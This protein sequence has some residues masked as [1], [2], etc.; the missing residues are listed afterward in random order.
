MLTQTMSSTGMSMAIESVSPEIASWW[1]QMNTHNRNLNK[2]RVSQLAD[3]MR[4][5][6]WVVNG[7]P[8]QFDREG[9]LINGQHRLH[10]IVMSGVT[11]DM[12]V[13]RGLDPR[14]Q[15]TIDIGSSR[16]MVAILTLNGISSGIGKSAIAVADYRLTHHADVLWKQ[17]NMP[18]RMQQLQMIKERHDEY[19]DGVNFGWAAGRAFGAHRTA[20]GLLSILAQ[21]SAS[22][23]WMEFHTGIT[24]GVGLGMDDPRLRLRNLFIRRNSNPSGNWMQQM[25]VALCIKAYNAYIEGRGI[26]N[27]RFT[28]D[29]LPMPTVTA[30]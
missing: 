12:L 20:Y 5:G 7:E 25:T 16:S 30:I 2:S 3:D 29:E 11:L 23:Q 10:A 17:D 1:L 15:D 28:R 18:T 27:L 14:A 22:N 4:K 26:K 6:L 8:I 19:A 9:R 21:R 13:V 24:D